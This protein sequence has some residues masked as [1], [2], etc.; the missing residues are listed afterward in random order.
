MDPTQAIPERGHAADSGGGVFDLSPVALREQLTNMRGLLVLSILM[1]ESPDEDQILNLATSSASSFGSWRVH[2]FA[3]VDEDVL[4]TARGTAHHRQRIPEDLA[5]ALT[6]LE[7][8]GGR[9]SWPVAPW[10]YATPMRTPG[11]ML[12]H[13]IASADQPPSQEEGFLIKVLAQQTAVAA[14][15][16]RL[17]AIERQQT[18]ELESANAALEQTVADLRRGTEIHARLTAAV[19][20]GEGSNGIAQIL[21]E[22]SG[23]P[24][25]IE[26]RHGNL[27][28]W[29]GPGEPTP[30]SKLSAQ[31]HEVLVRK[32]GSQPGSLRHGGRIVA[33]ASPRPG[34]AGLIALVD[35]E[36]SCDAADIMALE[37]SA[38]ALAVELARVR[39]LADAEIRLRRD[40]LHDLLAGIDDESAYARA[41]ALGYDLGSEH[42][43]LLV[44]SPSSAG[45]EDDMLHAVRRA[46]REV[47]IIGLLGTLT[48]SV[49]IVTSGSGDWEPLREVIVRE[50]GGRQ[51]NLSAGSARQRPSE[52]PESLR[53][54]QLALRLLQVL[55]GAPRST[56]YDDLGVFRMF[57]AIPELGHVDA[58]VRTWLGALIDYDAGKGAELLHTLTVYL[59]EGGHYTE[60]AKALM[61]HR[62]TLKYRLQRIR[63][64]TGFDLNDPE[65]NFNLQLATR[66]SLVLQAVHH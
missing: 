66:A 12:G 31:E 15:N 57:A 11:G 49:V 32:L 40:L 53:E 28:A 5:V 54:A 2:A 64:L 52:V 58:F 25:A 6:R 42:R 34:V 50:R 44:D 38:T 45:S 13:L 61:V 51:C 62:S 18:V 30:Y 23:R 9:L 56:E 19:A 4:W 46:M 14:S 43:V 10:T 60:T 24:V 48:G 47:G 7:E 29:A 20:S 8:M 21:H 35:P 16:A 39:G 65:T 41:D 22:L 17:R 59:A 36:D 55:G 27:R 1:T 33:M 26:D 37:H 3:F 63:E